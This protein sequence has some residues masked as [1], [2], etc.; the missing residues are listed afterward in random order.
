MTIAE[1]KEKNITELSRIP[2]VLWKSRDQRPSA[3]K[4]LSSRSFRRRAK[5]KATSSLKV[6]RG[7]FLPDGYGFLRSPDYNY[8]AR[9][10]RYLRFA[11][12]DSQ[13]RSQNRRLH[14]RQRPPASL[15]A[16]SISPLS[17][18]R[19]STS[20]L[21]KRRAT[22]SSLATSRRSIRRSASRWRQ[23]AKPSAAAS[24]IS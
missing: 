3:S 21:L 20:S 1:L 4:T 16:K 24:W 12:A 22:K 5:K 17:R 6:F 2:R 23:R 9:P 11:F 18:S 7:V 19:P 13:V 8:L 14:Q 10:G 15:K